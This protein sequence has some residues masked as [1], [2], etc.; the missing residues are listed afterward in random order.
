MGE[1]NGGGSNI[2]DESQI[3]IVLLVAESSTGFPPVLMAGDAV[4]GILFPVKEETFSGNYFIVAHSQR[5]RYFI[6]HF[7]ILI[8]A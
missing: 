8:Q 3:C 1:A 6:N 4:H 7:S 5:L 2:H